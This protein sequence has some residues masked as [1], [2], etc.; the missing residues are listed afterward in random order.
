M[1]SL[2]SP[3]WHENIYTEPLEALSETSP[4]FVFHTSSDISERILGFDDSKTFQV[5]PYLSG[6]KKYTAVLKDPSSVLETGN[7]W[8]CDVDVRS[9]IRLSPMTL[10]EVETVTPETQHR[11]LESLKH[12]EHCK[13]NVCPQMT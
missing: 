10:P 13:R 6:L 5:L 12:V 2:F 8:S 9:H 1:S 7:R 11:L 4:F 3:F